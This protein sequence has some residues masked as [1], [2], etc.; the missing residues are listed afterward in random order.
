VIVRSAHRG[1]LARTETL[2]G[3]MDR[4][5]HG[6]DSTPR[7]RPDP[8]LRRP[9]GAWGRTDSG[10][11]SRSR[12]IAVRIHLG[13]RCHGTARSAP[14]TRGVRH[15]AR[16]LAARHR[17]EGHWSVR[18]WLE[19]RRRIRPPVPGSAPTGPRTLVSARCVTNHGEIEGIQVQIRGGRAEF[20][21]PIV[22]RPDNILPPD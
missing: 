16:L 18:P 15:N 12:S 6:L 1:L 8:D 22:S 19:D 9:E 14:C 10:I 20:C 21:S 5:C 17:L 4:L 3:A 13:P 7:P 2:L 11:A